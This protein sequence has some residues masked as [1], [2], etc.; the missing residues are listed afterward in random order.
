[1]AIAFIRHHVRDY[2]AWRSVYDA[3]TGPT[4]A[5]NTAG[6]LVYRSVDDPNQ[7]LVIHHFSSP[8]EIEPWLRDERRRQAMAKAG[9][10]GIPRVDICLE[11]TDEER[12]S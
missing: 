3:F 10:E 12:P 11:P 8:S 1:M 5:E 4:S 2:A 7:L 9:V 6:P